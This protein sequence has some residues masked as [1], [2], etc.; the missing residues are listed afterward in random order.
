MA[1][2]SGRTAQAKPDEVAPKAPVEEEAVATP[3]KPAEEV[4]EPKLAKGFIKLKA[5]KAYMIEPFQRVAIKEGVETPVKHT[6]W[7]DAQIKA[8]LLRK[9]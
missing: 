8:G 4:A 5:V 3:E 9:C 7:V 1:R 6:G 2:N